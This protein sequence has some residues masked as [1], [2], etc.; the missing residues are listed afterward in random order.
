[1][2]RLDDLKLGQLG[3]QKQTNSFMPYAHVYNY[4]FQYVYSR[5]YI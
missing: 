2:H 1:M 4:S 3:Y 5:D